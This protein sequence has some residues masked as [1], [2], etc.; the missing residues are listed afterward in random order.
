M[1]RELKAPYTFGQQSDWAGDKYVGGCRDGKRHGQGTYTF[2][3]G[4][5]RDGT[6]KDGEFEYA[7]TPTKPVPVV[8]V[9]PK[10]RVIS[11]SSGSGFAVSSD[12]YVITNSHV[13]EGCQDVVVHTPEKDLR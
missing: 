3:D 8:K 5:V 11:A 2:A 1:I 13:I 12:G 9:S 7:K 6:W 4:T 10:R